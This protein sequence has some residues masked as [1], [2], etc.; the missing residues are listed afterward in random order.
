V[1]WDVWRVVRAGYASLDEVYSR[2]S[3]LD[4]L[5][6]HCILDA[7]EEAEFHAR[8]RQEEASRR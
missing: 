5:E 8:K 1:N 7:F 4:L 6:A 3:G 2:W